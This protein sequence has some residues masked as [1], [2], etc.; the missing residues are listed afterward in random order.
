MFSI[1]SGNEDGLFAIEAC[2]GQ[3]SLAEGRSLDFETVRFY[4]MLVAVVDK[5]NLGT[6][7]WVTVKILDENEIG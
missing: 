1:K 7:A 3:L 2:S 5:G 4:K 6:E